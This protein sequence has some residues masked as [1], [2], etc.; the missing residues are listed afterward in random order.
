MKHVLL[1]CFFFFLCL[2]I[3][4]AQTNANIAGTENVLVVYRGPVN[5]SDTISQGVKNYYQNAHNIPNKNIV[6]L[7]KY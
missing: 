3:V 2:N 4:E 7:M 6:G 1:F 5:E